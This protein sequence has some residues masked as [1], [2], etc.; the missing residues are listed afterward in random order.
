QVEGEPQHVQGLLRRRHARADPV[1]GVVD[2]RG[3]ARQVK[4]LFDI[5]PCRASHVV[6]HQFEV[7]GLQVSHVRAAAGRQVVETNDF[8]AVRSKALAKVGSEETC[9]AGR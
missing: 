3:R 7:G 9:A 4:Y 8:V 1:A 5:K 6:D 2:R